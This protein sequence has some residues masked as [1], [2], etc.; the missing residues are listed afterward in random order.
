MYKRLNDKNNNI[1]MI[2]TLAALQVCIT[3]SLQW[4]GV[5]TSA[6][7][8]LELLPGVPIFFILSGVLICNSFHKNQY[9][10]SK[11]KNFYIRRIKR[12]ICLNCSGCIRYC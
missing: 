6:T 7:E 12:I 5:N 4:L 11:V 10:K 3:H 9:Y 8:I 1:G 2:R